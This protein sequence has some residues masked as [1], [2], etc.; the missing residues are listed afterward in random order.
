MIFGRFEKNYNIVTPW[1]FHFYII[2]RIFF[3]MNF[4]FSIYTLGQLLNM[5]IICILFH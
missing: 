5:I 1:F 2:Y 4:E 3:R